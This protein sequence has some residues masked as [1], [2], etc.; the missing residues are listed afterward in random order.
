MTSITSLRH[1]GLVGASVL[2][3]GLGSAGGA[4]AADMH[5]RGEISAVDGSTVK[6]MTREGKTVSLDLA[7]GWKIIGVA[8]GS[9][10][11]IKQGS[12]IGTATMPGASD[13]MNAMEVLVLPEGM[14]GT[15]EG[16]YPWDL[17]PKSM[18]TNATV[19]NAVKEVDG[20]TVTLAYKGGEKK[21]AIRE[22]TPIVQLADA[23][24]EDVKTGV[25]VFISTA[26]ETDG[27]L[28]KGA[29]LVGKD[30]VTPPM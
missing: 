19:T 18:M 4:S 3:A 2:A 13:A 11:D 30:G 16:H 24:Q 26:S 8:K 15:G 10:A 22:A 17:Q 20:Q 1:F 21:V 29:I 5:V 6:V 25:K 23:T 28:S 9:M 12:F 27:K 14:R 7:E